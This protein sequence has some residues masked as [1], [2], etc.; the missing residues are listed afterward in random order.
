MKQQLKQAFGLTF[1]FSFRC[2]CQV[3]SL[4]EMK[5]NLCQFFTQ[6]NA[7]GARCCRNQISPNA[8]RVVIQVSAPIPP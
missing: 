1:S 6:D 4:E 7:H 8:K 5:N 2:F 3:I